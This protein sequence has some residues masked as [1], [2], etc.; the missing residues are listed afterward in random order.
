MASFTV[1]SV[2]LLVSR[3]TGEL[4]VN[5]GGGRFWVVNGVVVTLAWLSMF[6]ALTL[7]KV[8]VVSSL[9]GT[10]P[11]FSVILSAILLKGTEELNPRIVTG[12]LTIVAGAMVITLF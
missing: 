1:F 12:S 11:L 5:W 9:G 2:Y 6:T 3:R 10:N 4:Q 8:S 7:G